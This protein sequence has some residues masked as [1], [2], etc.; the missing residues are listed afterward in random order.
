MPGS[1]GSTPHLR[2]RDTMDRDEW[3]T[4]SR[5]EVDIQETKYLKSA[6][7]MKWLAVGNFA[8]TVFLLIVASVDDRKWLT[9][10]QCVIA[11]VMFSTGMGNLGAS[12]GMAHA[13]REGAAFMRTRFDAYERGESE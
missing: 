1:T 7:K 6:R 12:K 13:A 11:G 9:M 4:L 8:V 10:F 3:L 2:E 5:H